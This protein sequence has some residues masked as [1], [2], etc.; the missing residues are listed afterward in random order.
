MCRKIPRRICKRTKVS[1]YF[2]PSESIPELA[3][4]GRFLPG[5]VVAEWH[6]FDGDLQLLQVNGIRK[7]RARC[8]IL[9]L[10]PVCFDVV[11]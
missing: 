10:L 8:Y 3:R 9:D 1:R 11:R 5:V 6:G 2:D 7:V 4:A